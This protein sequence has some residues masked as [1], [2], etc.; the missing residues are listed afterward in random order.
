MCVYVYN[1]NRE[2]TSACLSVYLFI[3]VS[4]SIT[5]LKLWTVAQ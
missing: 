3:S 1:N 5:L 4:F 2:N